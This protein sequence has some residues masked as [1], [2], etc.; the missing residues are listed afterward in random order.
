MGKIKKPYKAE[1]IREIDLTCKDKVIVSASKDNPVVGT[2]THYRYKKI[3]RNNV[4]MCRFYPDIAPDSYYEISS[5]WLKI[6]K[7]N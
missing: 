4:R 1:L 2:V 3:G 6:I 5:N 7:N